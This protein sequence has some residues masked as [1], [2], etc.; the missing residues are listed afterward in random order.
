MALFKEVDPKRPVN[1][2]ETRILQYWKE[3][4]IANKSVAVR[5]G[6]P[7]WIFYEGPP[8]ANGRPGI[9]HLMSRTLKDIACRYKTMQGYQVHRK[10]G[11]DTHG[12][13]V[14]IEVEKHRGSPQA[15]DRT[16]GIEK[17]A[18]CRRSVLPMRNSGANLPSH[19]VL[20]DK[21]TV[22]HHGQRLCGDGLVD[23]QTLL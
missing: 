13:P 7:I 19:G 8:T 11:W 16:F 23:P 22:Y 10:A 2:V 1:D 18:Q 9:H 20:G 5:E 14:E 12:L 17:F 3:N 6:S 4:D 15:R 21:T